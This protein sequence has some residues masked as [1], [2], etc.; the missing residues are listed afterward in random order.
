MRR[1]S[2]CRHPVVYQPRCKR[3]GPGAITAILVFALESIYLGRSSV[4]AGSTIP[5]DTDAST[6][7]VSD[8]PDTL[9]SSADDRLALL[10]HNFAA[11]PPIDTQRL[12]GPWTIYY[13][14]TAR[15]ILSIDTDG[16]ID[17]AHS[18]LYPYGAGIADASSS[19]NG[20]WDEATE[21]IDFQLTYDQRTADVFKGFLLIDKQHGSVSL[22]GLL[23]QYEGGP[24]PSEVH[25]WYA[26]PEPGD[27]PWATQAH[28]AGGTDPSAPTGDW[29]VHVGT[30]WKRLTV[31]LATDGTVI[32]PSTLYP[33]AV[34]GSWDA[35]LGKITL[36][37]IFDE[38]SGASYT[39][40]SIPGGGW[41]ISALA[42][43]VEE[44]DGSSRSG[45]GWYAFRQQIPP[46]LTIKYVNRLR[47]RNGERIPT[48]NHYWTYMLTGGALFLGGTMPFE[49][50]PILIWPPYQ[51]ETESSIEAAITTDNDLEGYQGGVTGVTGTAFYSH[52]SEAD[53]PFTHPFGDQLDWNFFV[54]P[55]R[56]YQD[57]MGIT[58]ADLRHAAP[59]FRHP[60][61]YS[62]ALDQAQK[63]GL[64]S[65]T[66]ASAV[67]AMEVEADSA[68]FPAPY[69]PAD[70]DRV[71]V[72]GRW[73]V[74][75][76]HDEFLTEIHPPLLA[77][78]A[79]AEAIDRPV[80][81]GPTLNP[82]AT[83]SYVLGRPWL[84]GQTFRYDA[85]GIPQGLRGAI[86]GGFT[87][88][89]STTDVALGNID[90]NA[91]IEASAPIL[92]GWRTGQA[93]SAT[94][95]V[96][97]QAG[98]RSSGDSLLVSWTFTV[99]SGVSVSIKDSG[100]DGVTVTVTIGVDY[101]A[102]P[103]PSS[104]VRIVKLEDFPT[105]ARMQV[106]GALQEAL[107][108]VLGGATIGGLIRI[109]GQNLYD[110]LSWLIYN[111]VRMKV[112]DVDPPKSTANGL[113]Q[114]VDQRIGGGSNA[115]W[116]GEAY[117]VDDSQPF[118]IFGVLKVRWDRR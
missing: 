3:R 67:G 24:Q 38:R 79:Y 30:Q 107:N 25:G 68:L 70:G 100:D 45:T 86:E 65:G 35:T 4:Q 110:Q 66:D 52:H 71:A 39:G 77:V 7:C 118:P 88:K 59:W 91:Q 93:F 18:F 111:G 14:K 23:Y 22:A 53:V 49:W 116:T 109:P 114:F 96:R 33:D 99:R 9:V 44:S 43:V 13:G 8:D 50:L 61:D 102:A 85:A 2:L 97:P 12:Y 28:A 27:V 113:F 31:A 36:R 73:I 64:G 20:T 29:V 80:Y 5:I 15:L 82:D 76:G 81:R 90:K 17:P 26:L 83:V 94:Y 41:A 32:P 115:S 72:F 103:A 105:D 40:Y 42:G 37:V 69:R 84:V 63:L 60:G 46:I 58:N 75:A 56:P 98:R 21:A 34:T 54:V 11:P 57:L 47:F 16:H 55:D 89:L 51:K 95:T 92:P 87:D 78:R 117:T 112:Y 6:S 62:A 1:A 74:D 104:R 101:H 10:H 19:L 48:E 106:G 108:R